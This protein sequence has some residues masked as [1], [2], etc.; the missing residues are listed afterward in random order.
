MRVPGQ[1]K[2]IF[3]VPEST[4]KVNLLSKQSTLLVQHTA[5]LKGNFAPTMLI[6]THMAY[7]AF[8]PGGPLDES[9]DTGVYDGDYF[10]F[11]LDCLV[12]RCI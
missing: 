4:V 12:Q 9:T 1:E 8:M 11:C 5:S 10:C 6:H 3:G 7:V 2:K